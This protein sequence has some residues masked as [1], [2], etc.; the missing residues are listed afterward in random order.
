M[1]RMKHVY[2]V[3]L[4][5]ILYCISSSAFAQTIRFGVKAGVNQSK[6]TDSPYPINADY[7]LGYVVGSY[8]RIGALGLFLQPEILLSQRN[9]DFSNATTSIKNNLTFVDVPVLVGY[10]L[11]FFRVNGG[12]NFQYLLN[13]TQKGSTKDP[14]LSKDSFKDAIIGYQLGVGADVWK[15]SFDIRFDGSIGDLGKKV[16]N[17]AGQ[18]FNYS[19]RV[20]MWQFT[21][22]Y[23]LF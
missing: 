16:T 19:T 8:L 4:V 2:Y 7:R 18:N 20:N 21:V 17:A 22:G 9:A 11:A 6:F 10:K 15:L 1:D 5:G 14:N 23:R 13:S 12:P 3:L